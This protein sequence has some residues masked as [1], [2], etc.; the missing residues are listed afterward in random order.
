MAYATHNKT[1]G[2]SFFNRVCKPLLLPIIAEQL[3]NPIMFE[4]GIIFSSGVVLTA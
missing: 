1:D 4:K 3:P 2:M